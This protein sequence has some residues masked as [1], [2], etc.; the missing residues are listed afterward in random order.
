MPQLLREGISIV[1]AYASVCFIV[2][3]MR[4]HEMIFPFNVLSHKPSIYEIFNFIKLS[5][6]Q[7]F[8]V[9][10]INFSIASSAV[11]SFYYLASDVMR[12]FS[13]TRDGISLKIKLIKKFSIFNFFS[14]G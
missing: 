5:S 3:V 4:A 8:S 12:M 9:A 6:V 14:L 1:C 11:L 2:V 13:K 7:W 10:F